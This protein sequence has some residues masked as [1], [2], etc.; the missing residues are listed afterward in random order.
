[1]D[2]VKSWLTAKQERFV[3]EY[4]IDLNATAAYK[5]AGYKAASGRS[6]ENAASRLLGNVGV[7]RAIQAGQQKT[8]A[9]LQLT[10]DHVVDE[11]RNLAFSD[12]GD[13]LD[14]SGEQPKM[15]PANEISPAARRCISS[16]KTKRYV[17]GKGD[18]AKVVEITEFKL[19]DK[20]AALNKLCAH[21]G[22]GVESEKDDEVE[23][24]Q[25]NVILN[26]V[27][28]PD[29]PTALSPP[30]PALEDQGNGVL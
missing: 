29:Q 9:R 17:E 5:R 10:A 20:I 8:I 22:I 19:W 24:T 14:F 28:L 30:A 16:F 7:Q 6:A 23:I 18:D 4:L 13:I 26:G 11:I 12:I 25:V 21:L 3:Q 2:R 27:T 15:K 1:M